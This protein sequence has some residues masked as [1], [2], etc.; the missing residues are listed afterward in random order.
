MSELSNP[1]DHF[2]K[3]MVSR[4]EA[5]RDLVLNYLPAEVVATLNPDSLT[6]RKDSFVD[7]ELW[8][9]FSDLLYRVN[10]KDGQEAHVYVLF[11]H[12]SHAEP[13]VAF[14]LLRYMVQIWQQ[15]LREGAGSLAPVI[16]VVVYHGSA[17][18][19]VGLDFG[20]LF[21]GPEPLR[22]Y[23]P[24]FQYHLCD[25]SAYS[26][27]EIKGE[28][29]LRVGLLVLKHIFRD[30]FEERLPDI[31]TL[32]WELTGQAT[33]L[34]YLE[35]ILRYVALGTDRASEEGLRRAVETVFA[36]Q[37]GTAMRTLAEQ[38]IEQGIQ[39]GRRE[40]LLTGI[41][42][43]L[44]LKFGEAGLCLLPEIYKIQDADV[45]RAIY[46]GLKTMTAVDALRRIYQ[47]A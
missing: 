43:G 30:D 26:D 1:H 19:H 31:L 15:S 5:A 44:E 38:W 39:Q 33:G 34:E 32:L 3:W 28:V 40:G 22:A 35:T 17:A 11:E 12:K 13:L 27:A 36:R 37:G 46:E 14:Q 4:P 18:W 24:E 47:P 20:A 9:H 8:E 25:L 21:Q 42:L 16:P 10:L 29:A 45:L 7:E 2:F 23:W 41:E 6:L